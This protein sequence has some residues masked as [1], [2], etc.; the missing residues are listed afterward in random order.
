M[1]GFAQDLL[2]GHT[3]QEAVERFEQENR[4]AERAGRLNRDGTIFA[5][6]LFVNESYSVSFR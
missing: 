6:S 4:M 5:S 2:A 3:E 1:P